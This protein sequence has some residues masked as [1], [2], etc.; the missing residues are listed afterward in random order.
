M[1]AEEPDVTEHL[2]GAS[3]TLSAFPTQRRAAIQFK[4]GDIPH[5]LSMGNV[6][7]F[8]KPT[9][10]LKVSTLHGNV[11]NEP[12]DSWEIELCVGFAVRRIM[13]PHWPQ[14]RRLGRSLVIFKVHKEP[15]V[16]ELFIMPREEVIKTYTGANPKVLEWVHMYNPETEIAY[17]AELYR[18]S[19]RKAGRG[20]SILTDELCGAF[21]SRF[22]V[23]SDLEALK[24][25]EQVVRVT[26]SREECVDAGA[27][28]QAQIEKRRRK[29]EK[30]KERAKEEKARAKE[31][32]QKLK[33]EA[34]AEEVTAARAARIPAPHLQGFDFAGA[35]T[36]PAAEAEEESESESD[37]DG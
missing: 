18:P 12:S 3:K 19:A 7:S 29:K 6:G 26:S 17:W 9:A 5:E 35:M 28:A 2:I 11:H 14:V 32:G 25:L 21:G 22:C 31:E 37:S 34:N 33:A 36:K 8:A 15:K 16:C 1:F 30:Q 27:K 23:V 13:E 24:R 4:Y 20:S 10:D